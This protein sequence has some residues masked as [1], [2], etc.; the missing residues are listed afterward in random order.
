MERT[1]EFIGDTLRR[2]AQR[3]APMLADIEE[4]AN[5]TVFAAHEQQRLLAQLVNPKR[6]R[7]VQLR[8]MNTDIP[9]PGPDMLPFPRHELARIEALA[10]DARRADIGNELARH[11]AGRVIAGLRATRRNE[12]FF[13]PGHLELPLK[14]ARHCRENN[15]N[16]SAWI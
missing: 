16:S 14:C 4:A 12:F 10:V 2:L 11:E 13:D 5:D 9:R 8:D 1:F 6:A 3:V 15:T 7:L